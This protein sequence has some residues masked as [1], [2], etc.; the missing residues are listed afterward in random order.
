MLVRLC[1]GTNFGSIRDLEVRERQPVFDSPPVVLVD[2]KLDSADDPRPKR[3][4]RIFNFR[5]PSC[6]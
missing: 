4:W 5:S 2:L 6:G 1:Q 3:R